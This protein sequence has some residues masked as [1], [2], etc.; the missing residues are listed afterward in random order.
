ME[1]KK[2]VE[3]VKPKKDERPV[4]NPNGKEWNGLFK[5]ARNEM[6]NMAPSASPFDRVWEAVLTAVHGENESK[7]ESELDIGLR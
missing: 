7:V 3:P 4:L 1:S 6:G 5:E 2:V